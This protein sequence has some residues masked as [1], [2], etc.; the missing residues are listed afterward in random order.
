MGTA[1]QCTEIRATIHRTMTI[2]NTAGM[3]MIITG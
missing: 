2:A 1:T 3:G